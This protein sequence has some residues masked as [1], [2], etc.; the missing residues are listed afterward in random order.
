[1]KQNFFPVLALP[2][3]IG[4]H[5][6]PVYAITEVTKCKRGT[7]TAYN[8]DTYTQITG[9]QVSNITN[10]TTCISSN[11]CWSTS[12]QVCLTNTSGYDMYGECGNNCINMGYDYIVSDNTSTPRTVGCAC[13]TDVWETYNSSALRKYTYTHGSGTNGCT[14]TATSEY[15]CLTTHY[16]TAPNSCKACPANATCN[17]GTMF[18]CIDGYY[19][20]DAKTGC[21]KCPDSKTGGLG[22]NTSGN[23][24][25]GEYGDTDI[26]GCYIAE[27]TKLQD[28]TGSFTLVGGDCDYTK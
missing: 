24:V 20:N 22:W 2:V 8:P 18:Q 12:L 9:N 21:I 14:K 17:G 13:Q 15:K 19:K 6:A 7:C 3:L 4:L 10:E 11:N 25:A 5:I 27:G 23:G 28:A 1:M 26:T 16:G